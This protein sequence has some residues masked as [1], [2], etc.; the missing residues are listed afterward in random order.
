MQMPTPQAEHK[1]LEAMAGTWTGE[2]KMHPSPWDP[3]GGQ[4]TGKI[5]ARIDLAGFFLVMDYEQERGGQVGFK[6]HGV[7]GYDPQEK[8]YTMYWFDAMN[9]TMSLAKGTWEGN[10]LTFRNQNPMGHGRFT[11]EFAKEGRYSFRMEHSQDG[12]KWDTLMEAM[13]T[14]K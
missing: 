13:Y 7:F 4:A 14:R 5:R 6:G 11:Y 3:K 1:K 9:P 2:E 8:C 10:R 12:A